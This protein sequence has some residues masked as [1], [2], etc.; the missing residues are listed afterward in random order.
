MWGHAVKRSWL[1][2]YATSKK[3]AGSNPDEVDIFNWPYPSSRI[4]DLESTQTVTEMSISSL[5]G[6]KGRSARKADN[7]TAIC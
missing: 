1:M 4:M 7:L 5:P 3:V 6:D 2:H